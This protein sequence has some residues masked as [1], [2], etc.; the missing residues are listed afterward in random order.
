MVSRSAILIVVSVL[1]LIAGA[2]LLVIV[3]EPFR[4]EA[5]SFEVPTR[6]G[7]DSGAGGLRPSS[8]S[9]QWQDDALLIQALESTY[10]NYSAQAVTAQVIGPFVLLT[11][12]YGSPNPPTKCGCEHKTTVRLS[13]LPQRDYSVVRVGLP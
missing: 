9:L 1:A 2:I 11:I 4:H 8:F 13:K 7:A 6:C 5:T 12:K 10:C 3:L